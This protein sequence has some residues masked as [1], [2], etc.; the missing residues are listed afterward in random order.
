[1]YFADESFSFRVV[2]AAVRCGRAS[3][4]YCYI[5]ILVVKLVQLE[6]ES[7]RADP[8]SAIATRWLRTGRPH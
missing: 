7:L 8:A 2:E 6:M 3:H 1:M 4:S 5:V